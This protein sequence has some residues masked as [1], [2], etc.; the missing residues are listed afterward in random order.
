[1]Q[2]Q[3]IPKTKKVALDASMLNTGIIR[4][5]SKVSEA[6]QGKEWRLPQHLD[7]VANEK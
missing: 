3:V 1:M 6:I 2:G 4:Y 7:V 5:R